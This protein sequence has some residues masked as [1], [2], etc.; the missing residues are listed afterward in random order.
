MNGTSSR[1]TRE[2]LG[3]DETL[4]LAWLLL[5]ESKPLSLRLREEDRISDRLLGFSALTVRAAGGRR[6]ALK[7][8]RKSDVKVRVPFPDSTEIPRLAGWDVVSKVYG[9][10]IKTLTQGAKE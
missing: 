1:I 3:S 8:G 4:D 7:I 10:A 5:Q 6:M 2:R 9:E